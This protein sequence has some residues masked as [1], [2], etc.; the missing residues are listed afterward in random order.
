MKNLSEENAPSAS[1]DVGGIVFRA[2]PS[3]IIFADRFSVESNNCNSC[4]TIL[5]KLELL[6]VEQPDWKRSRL[7]PTETSGSPKSSRRRTD[8]EEATTDSE[9]YEDDDRASKEPESSS[10][11]PPTAE[12]RKPEWPPQEPLDLH[13]RNGAPSPEGSPTPTGT[14]LRNFDLHKKKSPIDILA[15]VFPRENRSIL[16]VV[17]QRNGGD[18][19]QAIDDLLSTKEPDADKTVTETSSDAASPSASPLSRIPSP[20]QPN[21]LAEPAP[22]LT[23]FSSP[24]NFFSSAP[25]STIA[26]GA[27]PFRRPYSSS[28][29]SRGLLASPDVLRFLSWNHANIHSG[30]S[31]LFR[32]D[33][34]Q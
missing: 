30:I 12:I 27:L 11:P 4:F 22:P 19:L 2:S 17:L 14:D 25:A 34:D 33:P 5:L 8:G 16:N 20:R 32:D 7:S 13:H 23:G 26:M 28:P 10:P 29:G 1:A 24:H 15:R 6:L 21:N 18:V 31:Q 9:P 3:F